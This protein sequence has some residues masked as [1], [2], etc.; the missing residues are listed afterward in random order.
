M[1][2]TVGE[3]SLASRWKCALPLLLS[4]NGNTFGAERKTC[5]LSLTSFLSISGFYF[6][7][8]IFIR[9]VRPTTENL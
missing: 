1:G 3:S 2:C 5:V 9:K 4:M 7:L 8:F 6:S